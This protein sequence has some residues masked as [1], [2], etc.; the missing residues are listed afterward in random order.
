VLPIDTARATLEQSRG[1]LAEPPV[2][3]PWCAG[4]ALPGFDDPEL[5]PRAKEI[6]ERGCDAT[7]VRP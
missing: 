3:E 6:L 5:V 2:V 7:G 1:T 4:D